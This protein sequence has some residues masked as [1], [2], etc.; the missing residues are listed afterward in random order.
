LSPTPL[1]NDGVKVSWYDDIPNIWKDKIHVPNHQSVKPMDSK[2]FG[3]LFLGVS[4]NVRDIAG[5]VYKGKSEP[6]MD[7]LGVLLF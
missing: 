5:M 3:G 1:K 6:N 7:D 4:K 2:C